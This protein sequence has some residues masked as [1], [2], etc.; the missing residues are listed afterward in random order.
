M[1]YKQTDGEYYKVLDRD[2][3]ELIDVGQISPEQ[4]L[5][6][7]HKV[8]FITHEEFVELTQSAGYAGTGEPDK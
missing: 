2:S 3:D 5:S 4:T 1:D 8:V 6:T 7:L